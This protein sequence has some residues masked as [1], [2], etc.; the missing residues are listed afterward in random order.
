MSLEEFE[1]PLVAQR[2]HLHRLAEGGTALALGKCPQ[3]RRVDDHRRRLVERAHE[4]LAGFEIHGRLASDRRV[5]LRDERRGHVDHGDPT[6]V[7]GRQ[8]PGRVTQR[9]AADGDDRLSALDAQPRQLLGGRFDDRQTLRGLA[10]RELELGDL[11]ALR[12]E[13]GRDT[14]A[15]RG[16]RPRLR[17]EDGAPRVE[18]PQRRCDLTCRD[19]LADDDRPD[20]RL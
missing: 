5:D 12:A 4:V 10:L 20:R 7:G 9:S 11:D 8:E 19:A 17:D 1:Q 14:R 13:R 16:P 6:E 15:E 3:G 18:L 2:R